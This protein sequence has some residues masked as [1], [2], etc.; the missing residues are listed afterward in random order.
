MPFEYWTKFKSGNIKSV[1]QAVICIQ[2]TKRD[3]YITELA[4]AINFE[5]QQPLLPHLG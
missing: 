2:N 3:F 4:W 1:N 5:V